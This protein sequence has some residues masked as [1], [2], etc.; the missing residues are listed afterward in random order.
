MLF[1][2]SAIR[3]E[4]KYRREVLRDQYQRTSK[5]G[6]AAKAAGL[7][8][9]ASMVLAACGIPADNQTGAPQ[10]TNTFDN[11]PTWQPNTELLDEVL[12]RQIV[13]IPAVEFGG[14]VAP[15]GTPDQADIESVLPQAFDAGVFSGPTW[16][17]NRIALGE[18]LNPQTDHGVFSGPTWQ[19]DSAK[20]REVLG[21]DQYTHQPSG[22]R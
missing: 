4:D 6:M 18:V 2:E 12:G 15:I 19:P 13:E 1:T 16:D 20:L 3:A 10:Q 5:V 11:G 14:M 17:P 21:T 9:V 7:V 8:V 22:P